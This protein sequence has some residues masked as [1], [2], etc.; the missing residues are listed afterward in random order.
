[1][2]R[3]CGDYVYRAN[4]V[5]ENLINTKSKDADMW[6]NQYAKAA[7][8]FHNENWENCWLSA[9]NTIYMM[10]TGHFRNNQMLMDLYIMAT[11]A[12]IYLDNVD[13]AFLNEGMTIGI[14]IPGLAVRKLYYVIL[15]FSRTDRRY[16]HSIDD[17][18]NDIL[19]IAKDVENRITD[20]RIA[21]ND[22]IEYKENRVWI[23][24]CYKL[25]LRACQVK[26]LNPKVLVYQKNQM[27]NENINY[28]SE[29]E[30]N[31]EED[32]KEDI[33]IKLRER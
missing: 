12:M 4:L 20:R 1:M 30:K 33:Q 17:K 27:R 26:S 5:W 11:E 19:A 15:E 28:L 7:R 24:K 3:K 16:I 23:Y 21:T 8:E 2:K 10:R 29:K 32:D 18:V 14:E 6:F 25:W 13:E 31:F 9:K 22:I